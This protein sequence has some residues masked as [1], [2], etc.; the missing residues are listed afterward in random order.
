MVVFE[1]NVLS[2]D[3]VYKKTIHKQSLISEAGNMGEIA[4][5]ELLEDGARALL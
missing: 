2:T 4:G 3:G 1:G 5:K